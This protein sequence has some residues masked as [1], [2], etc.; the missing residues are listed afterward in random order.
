M[1]EIIN[2]IL[3]FLFLFNVKFY[4][5]KKP[6]TTELFRIYRI[7]FILFLE[8]GLN[9]FWFDKFTHS[10][11]IIINLIKVMFI[12]RTF[13]IKKIKLFSVL[14]LCF[15][16][17]NLNVLEFIAQGSKNNN[18]LSTLMRQSAILNKLN[19]L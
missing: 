2:I 13:S 15:C 4:K 7:L 8:I 1:A 3:C 6:S 16:Q 12:I 9:L 11:F 5:W 14:F 18:F 10:H 19:I 17:C